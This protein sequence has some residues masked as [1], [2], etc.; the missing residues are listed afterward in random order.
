M[1]F[2]RAMPP[3]ERLQLLLILLGGLSLAMPWMAWARLRQLERRSGR[4]L[5]VRGVTG[6]QAARIVLLRGEID[7][8]PVDET[9]D[10][11]GDGY[12]AGE[13]ALKLAQR[14]YF[15]RTLFAVVRAAAIAGHGL[16]HR[17][18]DRRVGSLARLDGILVLWGNA[19][20]IL[21]CG[22][23]LSPGRLTGLAVFGSLAIGLGIAQ[24]VSHA[25]VADAVRRGRAEL[26][27]ARLLDGHP[28]GEIADALEA[29]RLEHLAAPA[30]RTIWGALRTRD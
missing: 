17:D 4:V 9:L 3:L 7:Q 27:G 24:A 25:T 5:L 14:T 18:R 20:P 22:V 1:R 28:A 16:Q 15:G 6:E 19:W 23:L 21:A 10:F 12:A 30:K 29:A 8:V 2:A 11:L 26:D 13:P